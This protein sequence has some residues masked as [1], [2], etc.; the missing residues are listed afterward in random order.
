MWKLSNKTKKECE[1]SCIEINNKDL[2]IREEMVKNT[3][4]L[5]GCWCSIKENAHTQKSKL[6]F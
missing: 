2:L 6:Q 1:I 5:N 4:N 3:L